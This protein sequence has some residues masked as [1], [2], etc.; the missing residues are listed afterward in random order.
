M[1]GE[2][3][4]WVLQRVTFEIKGLKL[5]SKMVVVGDTDVLVSVHDIRKLETEGGKFTV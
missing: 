2:E 1:T 3:E 5:T 4:V